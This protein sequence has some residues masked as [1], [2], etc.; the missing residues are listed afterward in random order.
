MT[1]IFGLV[2]YKGS[3]KTTLATMGAPENARRMNFAQPMRDM[4]VALGVPQIILDDKSRWNDP[5][6]ILEGKSIR[7]AMVTLGTEWGREHIGRNLWVNIAMTR[8]EV[9]IAWEE[10]PVIFDDVRFPNEFEAIRNSGGRLIAI[11][12]DGLISDRTHESEQHIHALRGWCD[13]AIQNRDDHPDRSAAILK[14]YIATE[15][16]K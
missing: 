8:A 9:I 6:P 5:L 1:K 15:L 11:H 13:F 7:H 16:N 10:R 3:G 14:D 2:G 4:L 12:R